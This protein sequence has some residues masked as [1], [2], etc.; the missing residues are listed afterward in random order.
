M[1]G[2]IRGR[3]GSVRDRQCSPKYEVRLEQHGLREHLLRVPGPGYGI[4][5]FTYI[6]LTLFHSCAGYDYPW[7]VDEETRV[8]ALKDFGGA[9]ARI[10]ADLC[11][12]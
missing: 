7:F 5:T 8:K 6:S 3:Q 9:G 10:R 12:F 4:H 11:E 2:G 1:T